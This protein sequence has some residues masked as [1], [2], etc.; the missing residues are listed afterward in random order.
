[1]EVR[2][3]SLDRETRDEYQIE[4]FAT[5]QQ[6]VH[7]TPVNVTVTILDVNDEFPEFDGNDF[8]PLNIPEDVEIDETVWNVTATDKDESPNLNYTFSVVSCFTP[9]GSTGSDCE[10][11][12]RME[13]FAQSGRLIVAK[14]LDREAVE[15]F[16]LQI[17]VTDENAEVREPQTA[18]HD[19][20]VTITDV[21]DNPPEFDESNLLMEVNEE[22]SGSVIG[23]VTAKD[24]DKGSNGV[25]KYSVM[26][27]YIG[28]GATTGQLTT[29][30]EIDR[31][32]NGNWMNVTVIATDE[33]SPPL[34]SNVTVAIRINDVND[35]SPNFTKDTYD[36]VVSESATNGTFVVDVEATD[37]DEGNNGQVRYSIIAGNE[38]SHFTID[39]ITGEITVAQ[40]AELDRERWPNYDLTIRA[41]DAPGQSVSN[42]EFATVN[43]N[44]TDVNDNPPEFTQQTYVVSNLREDASVGEL[45]VTVQATDQDEE[46]N[47]EITYSIVDGNDAGYFKI[48]PSSG[49]VLLESS[50]A[51]KN[52]SYSL[53]LMAFDGGEPPLNSTARLDIDVIDV[54]LN[55]PQ[56]TNLPSSEEI[57][58]YE[59]L[60]AGTF[61]FQVTADDKDRGRNGE[62]FYSLADQTSFFR[63]QA[64][65]GN[66]TTFAALDREQN[67]KFE[68]TVVVTDGSAAPRSNSTIVT[69]VVLDVDDNQ[70][71][72]EKNKEQT[73]TVVEEQ[74]PF[75]IPGAIVDAAS[76][77]DA[78]ENAVNYYFISGGTGYDSFSLNSTTRQLSTTIE[79][80]REASPELDLVIMASNDSTPNNPK[81]EWDPDTLS[82]AYMRVIIQ[83]EDVNDSPPIF[84]KTLYEWDMPYD[85][86]PSA[87]VTL[88]QVQVVDKDVGD[89]A[90][91]S[92]TIVGAQFVE[93]DVGQNKDGTFGITPSLSDPSIGN[94][95]LAK[96]SGVSADSNGYYQLTVQATDGEFTETTDVIIGIVNG[97]E[98]VL[99]YSSMTPEQFRANEDQFIADM[100]SILDAKVYVDKVIPH[101][102]DDT[103]LDA[104]QSDIYI[105]AKNNETNELVPADTIIK[106][107]E[108]QDNYPVLNEYQL[109][110]TGNTGVV[111]DNTLKYFQAGLIIAC[112]AILLVIIIFSIAILCMRRSYNRK[113]N[114]SKATEQA[115]QDML[116]MKDVEKMG[117]VPNTNIFGENE[118]PLYL[119]DQKGTFNL[120]MTGWPDNQES[121]DDDD[122]LDDNAVDSHD[123][124]IG[125][126]ANDNGFADQ[127]LEDGQFPIDFDQDEEDHAKLSAA[128]NAALKRRG[129][130]NINF[131]FDGGNGDDQTGF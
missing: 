106:E 127:P 31:E 92:F 95:F 118:N 5:D 8:D 70:P 41:Q 57:S 43:I 131:L 67:E 6:A 48:N 25:V 15:T 19:L 3:G 46:K 115:A 76:D 37:R 9:E 72:Y 75:V 34:S 22:E 116:R 14:P 78:P 97:D 44:I 2:D 16:N 23:Q 112:A 93:N 126:D 45:V 107:L 11:W 68:V 50:I 21:N 40:N 94:I 128:L 61:V 60:P 56:F 83:V 110:G 32:T 84:T 35:N 63:I 33:G 104:A 47:K 111:V 74:K 4:V 7:T 123:S 88:T 65:G 98:T 80:D 58:V 101:T 53:K 12:F 10:D 13:T 26:D 130:D 42:I 18:L 20:S 69:I 113:I 120:D 90:I 100:E 79:L 27:E 1:M 82:D 81:V 59:N 117:E 51:N 119:E 125:F 105:H 124:A 87:D 114:V 85:T 64:E 109:V 52:A 122:S 102:A 66:I 30:K 89:N 49:E 86:Q 99:L 17:L 121:R 62:V 29:E 36:A 73:I 91:A 77:K 129:E 55:T 38:L 54:N 39:E 108:R 28:I 71:S 103:S 24:S 96:A